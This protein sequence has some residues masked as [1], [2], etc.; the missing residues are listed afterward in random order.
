MNFIHFQL[1]TPERT[2]LTK[3]LESL[4]CPTSLG[5]ITIL[6]NHEPLVAN[7]VPGELI[8][9]SNG[10]K[11]YIN[12]TGGFIQ[13]KKN[14]DITVLADAAEHAYEIDEQRAKAAKER[15][16][17]TMTESKLSNEEYA[18]VAASLEKS[19]TRINISRKRAHRRNPITGDGVFSE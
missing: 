14:N 18:R 6:A 15:A 2:L 7:L 9:T 1:V 13:V 3:E 10:Q 8:A 12:V 19:L 16:E 4:S 17:K 11:E 5:Q